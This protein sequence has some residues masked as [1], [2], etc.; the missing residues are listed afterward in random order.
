M[1]DAASPP[2]SLRTNPWVVFLL[3]FAVYMLMNMLEPS[4]PTIDAENVAAAE[5][6]YA[7]YPLI[8]AGKIALTVA[9]I[10]FVLPGYRQLSPFRFGIFAVIVGVL[11][12]VLWI[13]LSKLNLEATLGVREWGASLGLGVRR[14]AFNPFDELPSLG[15]AWAFMALRLLGLALV[16]PLIEE[17]FYRGFIMR[18]VIE[19]EWWNVPFGKVTP[20]AAGAAI[21]LPV[22]THPEMLAAAAWFGL[23]VWLYH[24]TKNVWDCVVAHAIT[25]GLLGAY[26]LT[27]SDPVAWQL[28]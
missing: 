22:V 15:Q 12:V 24:H 10:V 17:M 21:L 7:R 14:S 26:V 18:F 25:N 28:L 27:S 1:T 9:A 3:P 23:M 5:Q 20:M 13:G 4:P 2:T 6:A 19:R 8:Y 16:V 11:G